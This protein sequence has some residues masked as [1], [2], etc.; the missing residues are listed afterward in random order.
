MK[1]RDPLQLR[2]LVEPHRVTDEVVVAVD[3]EDPSILI[4]SEVGKSLDEPEWEDEPVDVAQRI[5]GPGD[6]FVRERPEVQSGV[7]RCS[8]SSV[9]IAR[10]SICWP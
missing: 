2:Q 3:H 1:C 4:G 10:P 6:E 7:G 5:D 8:A 9:A